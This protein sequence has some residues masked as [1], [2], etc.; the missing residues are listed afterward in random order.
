MFPLALFLSLFFSS[1]SP[2]SFQTLGTSF[3]FLHY[4]EIARTV[5]SS[6]TLDHVQF[7]SIAFV[8]EMHKVSPQQLFEILLSNV[9][10][11]F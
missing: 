7:V 9:F 10:C 2:T 1:P 3:A 6:E 8:L 5:V 4:A 11:L